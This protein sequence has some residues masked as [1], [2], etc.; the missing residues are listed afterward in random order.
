MGLETN[1]HVERLKLYQPFDAAF[2]QLFAEY[3]DT[4]SSDQLRTR[5]LD[6]SLRAVTDP[7]CRLLVLTGDAGHG[8]TH[9]CGQLLQAIDP[10][11]EDVRRSLDMAT[12]GSSA[13][14]SV[15]AGRA[16]HLIKDLSELD[17]DIAAERLVEAANASDRTTIVCANEG[18]LREVVSRRR[19]DLGGLFRALE[20]V[21]ERGQTTSDGEVRI[22]NLN[23]QSVAGNE[24]R[25]LVR[26]ALRNWVQDG[27]KWSRCDRCD[28]RD[29][30]P[31]LENRN[32]LGG[33][34]DLARNR[35]DALSTLLRMAEQTNHTI[36]IRELLIFVA[37]TIT[38][39]L[40]CSD[41]HDLAQ[42]SR[43]D[44]WQHR[45]MFHQAA[46]GTR[47]EP[48]ARHRLEVFRA[49]G[50]LDPGGRAIRPVDDVLQLEADKAHGRFA[51]SLP[52]LT[53]MRTRDQLRRASTAQSE[54]YQFLRRRDYFNSAQDDQP[55]QSERLGF[56]YYPEFERL[57]DPSVPDSDKVDI[58][59]LVV[60][61]LEAVQGARRS[62]NHGSFAIVDPAFASRRGTASVV[63]TQIAKGKVRLMPQTAWWEDSFGEPP[64]LGQA[65][66]W[67]D[68]SIFVVLPDARAV[69]H[70]IELD[71]R[72]FELVCRAGAGLVS[73]EFFQAD[74]RRISARLAAI[75]AAAVPSDEITVLVAGKPSKLVIDIG[76][77]IMATD[78]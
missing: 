19:A 4:K 77:V 16:L 54:L 27:R 78:S 17:Q 9:L 64:D 68:R 10:G 6:Y 61:G 72:Q 26:Q 73:R 51:P 67:L 18:R 14:A 57:L 2:S 38:A 42:R 29:R 58:R 63:S 45:Y 56:R 21:L 3:V 60:A 24:E 43:E 36:T 74:I 37:H 35:R 28:V 52:N 33:D 44:D 8:K 34:D 13:L 5:A 65:V 32:L 66:D 71:C 11:I 50:L 75:A 20:L 31:I 41:V 7:S 12:D 25:S 48:S 1:E 15:G 69:A 47:L 62:T 53:A 49:T 76:D 23:Y 40:R 46:F 39:G 70:P 30:C 22:V 55:R 59:N